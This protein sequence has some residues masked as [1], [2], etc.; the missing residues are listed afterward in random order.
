MPEPTVGK[1]LVLPARYDEHRFF[2]RPVTLTGQILNFYTDTGGGLFLYADV[3]KRLGLPVTTAEVDGQAVSLA[4]LPAFRPGAAI[5]GPLVSGGRLPVLPRRAGKDGDATA[6]PVSRG[7]SGL[8]GQAWFAG[9]VWTFDYPG[10]RLLVRAPGD[11]PARVTQP[12]N[13]VPLGFRTGANG[14]RQ[15]NYPRI[16]V[17]VDDEPLDLLLDTGALNVLPPLVLRWIKDDRPAERTASFITRTVY[18]RWRTHH[19]DWRAIENVETLTGD[20]LIE[21]PQ[22]TVGGHVVGPVWFTRQPDRAFH[23]Y[24]AQFTD[25]P[26]EGALGG[27]GLRYLR[28]TVDYPNAVAYF[29]K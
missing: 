15:G 16:T 1:P 14:R 27:S 10:R 24:M 20:A 5:P 8:L 26:V 3:A 23:E 2:V 21:V 25:K 28:L 22:V 11:V 18:E 13:R 17:R 29:E 9:R 6:L 12:A 7:W 4:A 19:P